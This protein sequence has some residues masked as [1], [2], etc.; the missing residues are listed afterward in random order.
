MR[1]SRILASNG[2][3]GGEG[4]SGKTGKGSLPELFV[5][6]ARGQRR[7]SDLRDCYV[8]DEHFQRFADSLPGSRQRN[9]G[10]ATRAFGALKLRPDKFG[11]K[12]DDKAIQVESLLKA[13]RDQRIVWAP[14]FDQ[15]SQDFV[16]QFCQALA[17][18]AER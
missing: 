17:Q 10:V 9:R 5:W 2:V 15:A 6:R 14:R 12:V 7:W 8:L 13:H 1:I 11:L 16:R 4:A 18:Y 3:K